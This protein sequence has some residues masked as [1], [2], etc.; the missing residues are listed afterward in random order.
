MSSVQTKSPP[1]AFAEAKN[2]RQKARAAGMDPDRW[3]V[4]EYDDA[5]KKGQVKEVTFWNTSIALFRGEDGELSA[6]R[7]RCPHRQLKLSHGE[8]DGCNLR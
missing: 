6:V 2:S 7:N 4:V 1:P 3:Y 5:V 8:V